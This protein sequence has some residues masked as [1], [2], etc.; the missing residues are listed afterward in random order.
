MTVVALRAIAPGE[1]IVLNYNGEPEDRSA[2][3]FDGT[4]PQRR[5]IR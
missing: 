3:W 2:G 1:E 5:G 4:D